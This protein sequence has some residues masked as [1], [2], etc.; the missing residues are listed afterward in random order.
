[1]TAWNTC[2]AVVCGTF[3]AVIVILF[4]DKQNIVDRYE[5]KMEACA[6][7]IPVSRFFLAKPFRNTPSYH[8]HYRRLHSCVVDVLT[9]LPLSEMFLSRA[10]VRQLA[11]WD[12]EELLV[13]SSRLLLSRSC[14]EDPGV[15]RISPQKQQSEEVRPTKLICRGWMEWQSKRSLVLPCCVIY[16]SLMHKEKATGALSRCLVRLGL[17]VS[18]PR[19]SLSQTGPVH[20]IGFSSLR[21]CKTDENHLKKCAYILC[22]FRPSWSSAWIEKKIEIKNS[23]KN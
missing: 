4:L 13:S 10:D 7:I 9:R 14:V 20:S 2:S 6:C 3:V 18:S 12:I 1:M 23:K 22:N 16:L 5:T 11:N 17:D 8:E 15:T 19:R 21:H